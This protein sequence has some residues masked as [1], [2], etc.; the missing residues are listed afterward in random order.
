[1]KF[2]VLHHL[3]LGDHF[4]MNGF[5]HHLLENDPEEIKLVCKKHNESTV[6]KMYDGYNQVKL[7]TVKDMNEIHPNDN[8]LK[9]IQ[10]HVQNGYKYIGFG[11]HS[12]NNKYLEL[13]KSWANCFYLQYNLD[14]KMRW[15][16]FK[17]PKDTSL[18]LQIAQELVSKIGSKYIVLHDDPSRG[19]ILNYNKVKE[20]LEKDG[21]LD[22]PI[23]Y[24]GKDR[25]K[26]PLIPGANNPDILNILEKTETLYDYCYILG[27]ASSCHM[28]DSSIALLLDFIGSHE[29]QKKYM[30]EYAK[31]GE[32][33][34]TDGLFQQ[35]WELLKTI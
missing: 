12:F 17:F 13:D 31:V 18:S 10:E 1:M 19:F 25:Y 35:K 16:K 15:N 30:H 8:P 29:H 23:V 28:M 11:V 32:I 24:L 7:Y 21:M 14:P 9:I 5:I 20:L 34:S 26:Y 27:N 33:L 3:G 2:F 6:K 4:V 22:Y